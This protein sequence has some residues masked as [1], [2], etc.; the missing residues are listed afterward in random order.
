MCFAGEL[1]QR[2]SHIFTGSGVLVF[3]LLDLS[4]Y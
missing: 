2:L 4:A 1:M 3:L